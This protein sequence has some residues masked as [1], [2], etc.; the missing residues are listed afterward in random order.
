MAGGVP[1]VRSFPLVGGSVMTVAGGG[2]KDLSLMATETVFAQLASVPNVTDVAVDSGGNVFFGDDNG[3]Q[4][5]VLEVN[6]TPEN[7][8][9]WT[10][11]EIVYIVDA[12]ATRP[13]SWP[14]LPP[15][16]ASVLP[17]MSDFETGD[18]FSYFGPY[19]VNVDGNTTTNPKADQFVLSGAPFNILV[20][21]GQNGS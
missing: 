19:W 11:G 16:D 13:T 5:L 4:S 20:P 3:T 8:F 15:Y 1:R 7:P 6:N 17:N 9:T 14:G 10:D 2:T 21:A 18:A 12:N